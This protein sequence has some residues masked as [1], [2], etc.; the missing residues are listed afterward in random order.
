LNGKIENNKIFIKGSRKKINNQKYKDQIESINTWQIRIE[1]L[2]WKKKSVFTKGSRTKIKNKK[3]EDRCRNEDR[4]VIREGEDKRKNKK[5]ATNDKQDGRQFLQPR[6]AT[7]T[8]QSAWAPHM[9]AP[10]TF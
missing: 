3:K 8:N 9:H 7:H 1:G 6:G 2:N 10:T 5:K 4:P